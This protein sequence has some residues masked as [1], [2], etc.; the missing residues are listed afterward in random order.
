MKYG[1][2]IALIFGFAIAVPTATVAQHVDVGPGGVTV[3][4]SRDH[5]RHRDRHHRPADEHSRDHHHDR[6]IVHER[7]RDHHHHNVDRGEH[8][9]ASR[10]DR[11]D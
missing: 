2:L 8:H 1:M 7:S 11:H 10:R 9:D 6:P 5:E 3:G 4:V